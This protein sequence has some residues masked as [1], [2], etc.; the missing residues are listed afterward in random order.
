MSALPVISVPQED[1][2]EQQ[3]PECA[4]IIQQ[5]GMFMPAEKGQ[6][7]NVT[8]QSQEYISKKTPGTDYVI[9]VMSGFY[10]DVIGV[11]KTAVTLP[12]EALNALSQP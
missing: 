6:S 4:L 3:I 11:N 8:T 12:A 5:L 10:S 9:M 1:R 2:K 7:F